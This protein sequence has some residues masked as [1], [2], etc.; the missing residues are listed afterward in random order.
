MPTDL[1]GACPFE[2]GPVLS[3]IKP[4][5]S[6]FIA[7]EEHGEPTPE[8]PEGYHHWQFFFQLEKDRPFGWIVK[9]I[10]G[11]HVEARKGP[12]LGDVD[13]PGWPDAPGTRGAMDY[14]MKDGNFEQFGQVIDRPGQG[15]RSDLAIFVEDCKTKTD[16]ELWV[17]H[18]SNMVR[19]NRVPEKVR[20]AFVTPRTKLT[21]LVW[22]FGPSGSGKTLYVGKYYQDLYNKDHTI[23]WNNYTGQKHVMM[24]ELNSPDFSYNELLKIGNKDRLQVQVKGGYVDFVSETFVITSN[25]EP[26]QVYQK[27]FAS[28][29]DALLRRTLFMRARRGGPHEVLLQRVRWAHGV[30]VDQGP[31]LS[32]Q[33]D[34]EDRVDYVPL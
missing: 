34:Y 31:E 6:Y 21:Q 2:M 27:D 3:K 9:R 29:P 1:V 5:C 13:H 16:A 30:W 25:I 28:N 24:D 32:R 10:P 18:P 14:C 7:G 8:K 23:W 15:A 22:I 17:A 12:V 26:Q 20:A 33:T 4:F 19:Y 11:V